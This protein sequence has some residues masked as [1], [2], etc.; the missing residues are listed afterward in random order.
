MLFYWQRDIVQSIK[1]RGANNCGTHVFVISFHQLGFH[2]CISIKGWIFLIVTA[3]SA[4]GDF[5]GDSFSSSFPGVG[6]G[7]NSAGRRR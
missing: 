2:Q 1:C 6:G 7:C 5:F 3:N 4:N